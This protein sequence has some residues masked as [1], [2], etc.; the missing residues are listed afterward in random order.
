MAF[1]IL[2]DGIPI[3]K[4][5]QQTN[6]RYRRLTRKPVYQGQEQHLQ[7][8]EAPYNRE[9]LWKTGYN[10]RNPLYNTT[11]ALNKLRNHAIRL[12]KHHAANHSKELH[13]D[14]ST[15]A[16]RKGAEGSQ[17]VSVFSNLGA[18]GGRYNLSVPGAFAPGTEA[19]DVLSCETVTADDEGN[20]TVE[21]NAGKP[22]AFFPAKK[23]NGSG[24]CG[25]QRRKNALCTPPSTP[26]STPT[27]TPA[28]TTPTITPTV[29]NDETVDEDTPDDYVSSASDST[30]SYIVVLL[31]A[32]AGV[33][34]WLL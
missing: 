14:G 10:S 31:C 21:M 24:L 9:P 4:T 11:R 29:T 12:D 17:I 20:I 1:N 25:Y 2:S 30:V 33:A 19:V 22:K 8:P 18:K 3:G 15:Y 13:V 16:T 6:P 26:P 27:S 5:P 32:F 34:N 7:G 23:M 28:I